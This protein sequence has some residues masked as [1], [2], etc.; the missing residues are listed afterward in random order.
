[1]HPPFPVITDNGQARACTRSIAN[2]TPLP[3]L[4]P[5]MMRSRSDSDQ[6]ALRTIRHDQAV[7]RHGGFDDL[8]FPG[9]DAANSQT[10]PG[11][12]QQSKYGYS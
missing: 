2:G 4:D 8:S 7:D 10:D 6:P 12:R 5:P 11:A 1:M 3:A 9:V